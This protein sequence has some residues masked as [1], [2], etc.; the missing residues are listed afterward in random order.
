MA[1]RGENVPTVISHAFVA[2][3]AAKAFAPEDASVRFYLAAVACATLPDV[4]VLAFRFG[5]PYQHVLGHR[6]FFHSLPFALIL[7]ALMTVVVLRDA[8]LFSMRSLIHLFFF[9]LVGATHGILDA[10]TDG[11]LGVALYSPMDNAR[12]FFPW[13]PIKVSPLGFKAFFSRWGYMV[14]KSELLWIWVPFSLL[15]VVSSLARALSR[16]P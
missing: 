3:A 4:D 14:L 5:I 10:L 6:G 1:S 15:V 8:Q 13:T 9:F 7:S 2:V 16:R 12:Y 11:G